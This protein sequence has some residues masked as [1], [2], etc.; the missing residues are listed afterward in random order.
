MVSSLVLVLLVTPGIFYWLRER[1]LHREAV[2]ETVETDLALHERPTLG[3]A[4][5]HG[6]PATTERRRDE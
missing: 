6:V 3:S 2:R 4:D 5:G 1:E